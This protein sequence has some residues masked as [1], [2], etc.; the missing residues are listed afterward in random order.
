MTLKT[1]HSSTEE[2]EASADSISEQELQYLIADSE[3]LSGLE[4]EN[5]WQYDELRFEEPVVVEPATSD[6]APTLPIRRTLS[7]SKSRGA[8]VKKTES[9]SIKI[10]VRLSVSPKVRV[11]EEPVFQ[12]PPIQPEFHQP[13]HIAS[14][15]EHDEEDIYEVIEQR[16]LISPQLMVLY[17]DALDDSFEDADELDN[18]YTQESAEW[19][20]DSGVE[21]EVQVDA[22]GVDDEYAAYAFDPEE[23]YESRDDDEVLPRP[24]EKISR[25]DRAFQKATDLIYNSGW[26]L[27][28][29]A[30]VHQIFIINGWGATRLALERE[31]SKG[32][33]PDE[34]ILAAHIKV[35]W[36]Q[37]DHYW[38]AFDKNGSS[39][40]S[41]YILSWP[42]AIL[43][44]RTFEALPQVEELEHFI[45]SQFEHWYESIHLRRVFRSFNR[46]L[47]YRMSNLRGCLPAN[48]PFSFGDPRD[49][50]VEEYSDLGLD[51]VLDIEREADL[52]ALGVVRNKHPL[53]PFCYFSDLPAKVED[54]QVVTTVEADDAIAIDR[55]EAAAPMPREPS[56][57]VRKAPTDLQEHLLLFSL[58]PLKENAHG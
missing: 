7:L 16:I 19:F 32:M 53:E 4:I 44:V 21:S 48:M 35:L 57:K 15:D 40:L 46:F 18:A 10:T 45:D 42:S 12:R 34:L 22:G 47:W 55:K 1:T 26:P 41:Q 24:G 2:P 13:A 38:I 11:D 6:A 31:I 20:D 5:L 25:E 37:N 3:V 51:D 52:R 54:D 58:D 28:A 30:L 43:I 27:S 56:F 29:H 8:D 23:F 33:T 9:E 49:L 14:V 36:A 50:P 17:E 39:N